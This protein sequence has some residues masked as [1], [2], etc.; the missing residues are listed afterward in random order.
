[1]SILTKRIVRCKANSKVIAIKAAYHEFHTAG[2][3]SPK[4]RA[5]TAGAVSD[6]IDLSG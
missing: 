6:G 3:R 5:M 4:G 2:V 1:M